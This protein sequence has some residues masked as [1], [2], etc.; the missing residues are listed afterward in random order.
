MKKDTEVKLYMQER[1]KGTAQR[2]REAVGRAPSLARTC[3]S[4]Y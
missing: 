2:R 1:R 4:L 3:G